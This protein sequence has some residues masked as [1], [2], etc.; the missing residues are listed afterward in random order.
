M[1][2]RSSIQIHGFS[3]KQHNSVEHGILYKEATFST[4]GL[5]NLRSWF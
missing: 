2:T 5:E 3:T 1:G 4:Y